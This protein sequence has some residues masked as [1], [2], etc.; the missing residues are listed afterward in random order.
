MQVRTK[1]VL[2]A[3]GALL[4]PHFAAAQD[5]EVE[6]SVRNRT[7]EAMT[8]FALWDSGTRV[9]LG[10]LN[11]NRSGN[12]SIPLRGQEVTL[13]VQPTEVQVAGRND[14][15]GGDNPSDFAAVRAGTEVEWEIR[16]IDPLDLF[17]RTSGGALAGDFEEQEPRVS[18]YTALS[19]LR[20]QE[21][22][23]TEDEVEQA[24]SYREA[25][26]AINEGIEEENDNPEAYLHLGIVQ[27]ALKDYVAAADAFDQAELLY[28]EYYEEENGTKMFRFNGWIQAYNDATIS[29]QAQ[30]PE[31][32][33]E[34]F[35]IANR[36][37][38][39]RPEGYL[40]LGGQLAGLGDLEG[41]VEAWRAA[42][43]IID[44]PDIDPDDDPTRE[45]WDNE[46]WPMAHNNLG[47]I[48]MSAGRAEEAVS[49]YE[50][51]LAR[52]PDNAQARSSLA[53]ALAQSGQ[54]DGGL[55]VFDEILNREDGSA[56]DYF[57]AGVSLYTAEQ[58]DRA[59]VGFEKAVER[60]P[61]YRDALQNLAQTLNL[62]EDF[63]AQVPYSERLLEL[64]PYNEYGYQM[65]IRALVEVGRQSDGVAVLDVMRDLPFVT[66]NLQL[67]PMNSGA[68]VSG[69]AINKTLAPGT[70]ITLR[71]TFYD[72]NSVP[73]GS[74]DIEITISDPE[75][76]HEFQITFDAEMQVLGYGYQFLN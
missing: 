12:Y 6:L 22:Q 60:A 65:H 46:F 45:S 3:L 14:R 70:T 39:E 20:I 50:T 26:A 74:E 30:D 37:F 1:L 28:P 7:S 69:Y 29:L 58:T 76:A 24:E 16:R 49:V 13:L 48:L 75:V 38:E 53:L 5:E 55:A 19:A 27:T 36:L 10:D 72:S 15:I 63:E 43:A 23:D 64:D 61:M 59:A 52:D 44:N 41:S 56:L 2:F 31:G 34:F 54:G 11:A 71:F 33:V 67:Q 62:L 68:R 51:L 42:I 35:Q 40:N 9:R 25:L 4:V 21:A 47:Q 8:V 73:M 57:N 18:R 66:D 32:A 17:F